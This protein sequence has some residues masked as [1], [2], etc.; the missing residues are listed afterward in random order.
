MRKLLTLFGWLT[1]MSGQ[2]IFAQQKGLNFDLSSGLAIPVN[3]LKLDK[4]LIRS[5]I[6]FSTGL[7]YL[8][9]N[10]GMEILSGYFEN[11]LSPQTMQYFSA[12]PAAADLQ[13]TRDSRQSVYGAVGPVFRL[14]GKSLDWQLSP[15][16]G[17]TN[18]KAPALG[19]LAKAIGQSGPLSLQAKRRSDWQPH[20][21]IGTKFH[22]KLNHRLGLHLKAAYLEQ[23]KAKTEAFQHIAAG[24]ES[25]G[26]RKGLKEV[27]DLVLQVARQNTSVFT[28]GA[29]ITYTFGKEESKE[30]K[31]QVSCERSYLLSP[32]RGAIFLIKG[33]LRPDFNWGNT[34]PDEVQYYH[35]KLY[36]G[37]Q[38]VYDLKTEDNSVLHNEK[39][40]AAY[41][42]STREQ[43]DYTWEVVTYFRNCESLI[44]DRYFFTMSDRSGAFHDIF[45][46]ECDEPAYTDNGDQRLT[47]KISFFNNISSSDPLIIN[48]FNDVI[49]QDASGNPLSGVY[50]ANVADCITNL[51]AILPIVIPPGG[52]QTFCFTLIVPAGHAA[53]RSEAHGT[54]DGLPQLSTDQDDLPNCSCTVCDNWRFSGK[55]SSL[56]YVNS[57]GTSFNAV[58]MQDIQIVNADPIKEV[59]AEIVYVE[60]VA[61]DPQCYTCTRHDN[62]MGLFSFHTTPPS[63]IITAGS[64]DNNKLGYKGQANAFDTNQDDYVNQILWKA[65]DPVNGV[66]LSSS[67]HRFRMPLNL[68]QP[69]TLKCCDHRYEVCIRYTITDV[70]CAT[71]DFLVC[72]RMSPKEQGGGLGTGGLDPISGTSLGEISINPGISLPKLVPNK[73]K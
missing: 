38:L 62:D 51:P 14:A 60:H 6:Q 19:F 2:I 45:D 12:L 53:I 9:K 1:L 65:G 44:S 48:D 15:K 67:S 42:E 58:I 25:L 3:Q 72:Y 24:L 61:N 29:G 21:S 52:T 22:F 26:N 28:L 7:N 55:Q 36:D 13:F 10:L 30:E 63:V 20:W 50:L 23:R 71:C 32:A 11:T 4:P 35:F 47:G 5:G 70:N 59:K 43:T 56:Q 40:E 31:S 41:Q 39:L 73:R 66:D 34:A 46:L 49:I 33:T 64:W 69:S 8:G 54:I 37:Q 57:G 18:I 17:W 27:Q 68:P 16:L